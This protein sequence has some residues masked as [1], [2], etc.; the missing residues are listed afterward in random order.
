MPKKF[1]LDPLE[2]TV[3][4][5]DTSTKLISFSDTPH[6][7]VTYDPKLGQVSFGPTEDQKKVLELREQLGELLIFSLHFLSLSPKVVAELNYYLNNPTSL[8]TYLEV[9]Y[10]DLFIYSSV[11]ESAKIKV[12]CQN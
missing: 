2:N 4:L 10:T 9:L 8:L 1:L 12:P 3:S 7:T 5:V 11:Q 6:I